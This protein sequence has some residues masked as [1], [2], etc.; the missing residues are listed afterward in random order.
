LAADKLALRHVRRAAGSLA[1]HPAR[2]PP[3]EKTIKPKQPPEP[4]PPNPPPIPPKAATPRHRSRSRDAVIRVY[5]EARNVIETHEHK[6]DFK[7]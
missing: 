4:L 5:D 7:E 2:I 6:G 3:E 1:A